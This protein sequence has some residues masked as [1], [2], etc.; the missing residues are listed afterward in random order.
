MASATATYTSMRSTSRSDAGALIDHRD[1]SAIHTASAPV[2][3]ANAIRS[4]PGA[5]ARSRMSSTVVGTRNASATHPQDC[6]KYAP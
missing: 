4:R 3:L 2:R 5:D 6:E 1:D